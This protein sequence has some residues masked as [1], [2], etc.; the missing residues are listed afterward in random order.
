LK[1]EAIA[2]FV[3]SDA[4]KMLAAKPNR[5]RVKAQPQTIAEAVR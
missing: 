1:A 4:E 2:S 3:S 5:A